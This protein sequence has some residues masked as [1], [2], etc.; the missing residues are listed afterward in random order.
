VANTH[1]ATNVA[2]FR[3]TL[4]GSVDPHGLTTTV[5]FQVGKTISYEVRTTANQTMTGNTYQNVT[6]NIAVLAERTRYHFRIVATNS[7]GTRYGDDR[8]F[9]TPCVYDCW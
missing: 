7:A 8:T 3:P 4:H 9:Q 5:H 6:A 1:H 2:S